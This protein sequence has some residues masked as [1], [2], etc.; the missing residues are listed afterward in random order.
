[1]RTYGISDY[2]KCGVITLARPVH[3]PVKTRTS[4]HL[5]PTHTRTPTHPHALVKIIE[6]IIMC[7]IKV[8]LLNDTILK[9]HKTPST[10]RCLC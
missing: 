1:M 5:T 10:S 6:I 3:Y 8:Y 9:A 7:F 2:T 4:D